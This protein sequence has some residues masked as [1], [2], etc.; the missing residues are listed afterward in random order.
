MPAFAGMTKNGQVN[1]VCSGLSLSLSPSAKGTRLTGR[2]WFDMTTIRA[3]DLLRGASVQTLMGVAVLTGATGGLGLAAYTTGGNLHDRLMDN[4][5][6]VIELVGNPYAA[7]ADLP[8]GA[9]EGGGI[10]AD[11]IRCRGC[12]PSIRERLWGEPFH[13]VYD[14]PPAYEDPYYDTSANPDALSG[15]ASGEA[16]EDQH[17]P[18]PHADGTPLPA[19]PAPQGTVAI[20]QRD[21]LVRMEEIQ[22]YP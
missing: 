16:L 15:E 22:G 21:G 13:A 3:L 4:V 2:R 11:Q 12:G 19:D 8:A 20:I 6:P 10:P 14:E 1:R 9:V 7:E 5:R 18:V 17:P